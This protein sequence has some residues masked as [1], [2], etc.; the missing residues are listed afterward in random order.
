MW[1]ERVR[2]LFSVGNATSSIIAEHGILSK[3]DTEQQ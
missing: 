2:N 1:G 3:K